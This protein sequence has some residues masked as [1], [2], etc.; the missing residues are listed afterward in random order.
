[1]TKILLLPLFFILRTA[2]CLETADAENPLAIG[3]RRLSASEIASLALRLNDP[4]DDKSF[5]AA[6]VLGDSRN[7]SVAK[8]LLDY[9]TNSGSARR[10]AAVAALG[11]LDISDRKI[12][13][14]ALMRIALGDGSQA[15]RALAVREVVQVE[16]PDDS[17]KKI[18]T[19]VNDVKN[20]PLLRSR[21]VH[22]AA[23]AGN[24]LVET[25]MRNQL[26][27][28]DAD[29]AIA[30]IE[31]LGEMRD[32]ANASALLKSAISGRDEVKDAAVYAL[33]RLSG[34]HFGYDQVKWSEWLKQANEDSP[35]GVLPSPKEITYEQG[36]LPVDFVIAFDTTG[37]FLHVWAEVSRA[38]ESVLRELVRNE[39]S[40]RIG[41]VRYRSVDPRATLK[42]TLKITPLSYNTDAL[43]KE[44]AAAS[45]GGGSGAQHE[46]IRAALYGTAWRARARKII[47]V[48]GDDSPSSPI[49]NALQTSCALARDAGLVDGILVNTLFAKTTAGEENRSTYR[50]IALA[51]IGR[52]YEFNKAERRLVEMGAEKVDVKQVELPAETA[53]KWLEPRGLGKGPVK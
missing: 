50:M 43:R 4:D 2:Q 19:F 47:L 49:E 33:E 7:A 37:S 8:I 30:A 48:I 9:Y 6:K 36:K 21:A 18:S 20:T 42:Y 3:S 32:I 22:S 5:A 15:V 23:L 13:S 41:L 11:A 1:M 40:V 45:F 39:P 46:G 16:G 17:L 24:K 35:G 38:L 29:V 27:S 44:L 52:F 14:E 28:P 51:G 34:Q 25:L 10:L 31:E 26:D 53:R 12:K